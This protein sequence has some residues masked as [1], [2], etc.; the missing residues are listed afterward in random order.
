LGI[1][2]LGEDSFS[3]FAGANKKGSIIK[4][5]I[6]EVDARG[7]VVELADNVSGYLKASE[8]SEERVEDASSIL[9]KGEEIEAVI[10]QIDR[11]ARKLLLSIK[12]KDSV[13]EKEAMEDYNKQSSTSNGS[14]LGDLLKE[15]KDK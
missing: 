2:Q 3:L 14:K 10:T 1:K 5:T 6:A 15:A 13:E 8:I 7:A 4:G 9:K 11:R 12:A